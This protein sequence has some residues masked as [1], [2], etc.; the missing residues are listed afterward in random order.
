MCALIRLDS[1]EEVKML[2]MNLCIKFKIRINMADANAK[3]K[4]GV[5]E[6]ADQPWDLPTFKAWFVRNFNQRMENT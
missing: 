1:E 2:T 3:I 4:S 5:A 6:M